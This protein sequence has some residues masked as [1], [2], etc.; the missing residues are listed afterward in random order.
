ML[1]GERL[2]DASLLRQN[3]NAPWLVNAEWMVANWRLPP[4]SAKMPHGIIL[5][6]GPNRQRAMNRRL[7]TALNELT[8][9]DPQDNFTLRPV[10]YQLRSVNQSRFQKR[11]TDVCARLAVDSGVMTGCDSHRRIR[12]QETAQMRFRH[13]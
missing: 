2:F 7:L 13:R 12:E 8:I 3:F 5:V 1:H 6:T 10:E 9:P 4:G 11:R